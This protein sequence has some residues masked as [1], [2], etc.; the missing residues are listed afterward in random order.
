MYCDGFECPF[1]SRRTIDGLSDAN[2]SL[3]G[4]R[5]RRRRGYEKEIPVGCGE[6]A[7]GSSALESVSFSFL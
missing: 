5:C 1:L 7:R 6:V 4:N 3:S 2:E